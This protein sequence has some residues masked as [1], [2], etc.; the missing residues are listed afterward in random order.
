M[1]IKVK[2]F[3]TKTFIIHERSHIS[4]P[5]SW[6]KY[7]PFVAQALNSTCI[8]LKLAKNFFAEH[9]TITKIHGYFLWIISTVHVRSVQDRKPMRYIL[10]YTPN[11]ESVR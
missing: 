7:S 11:E 2:T 8:I 5:L 9:Q 1:Y 4:T 10:T 6:Q 3:Q